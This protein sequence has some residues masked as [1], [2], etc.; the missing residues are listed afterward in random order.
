ME[1][2]AFQTGRSEKEEDILDGLVDGVERV[3]AGVDVDHVHALVRL[4]SLVPCPHEKTAT[5]VVG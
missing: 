5:N 1:I 3:G 2:S 4:H